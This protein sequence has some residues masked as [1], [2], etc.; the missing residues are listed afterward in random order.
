MFTAGKCGVLQVLLTMSCVSGTFIEHSSNTP[1]LYMFLLVEIIL[2]TTV[3]CFLVLMKRQIR[4]SIKY[5]LNGSEKSE[6]TRKFSSRS[7]KA[8]MMPEKIDEQHETIEESIHRH[9][10]EINRNKFTRERKKQLEHLLGSSSSGG[11]ASASGSG[12][13]SDNSRESQIRFVITPHRETPADSG[14]SDIDISEICS[15]KNTVDIHYISPV[16]EDQDGCDADVDDDV[17][18]PSE[19]LVC[20]SRMAD[21]SLVTLH[22]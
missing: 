9:Q 11:S 7:F 14:I 17:D 21:G 8:Y 4:L 18:S 6:M 15:M 16:P 10:S 5:M 2:G 12:S 13:A 19:I 3:F 22:T 20:A 1:F